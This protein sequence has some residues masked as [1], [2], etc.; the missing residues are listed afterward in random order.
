MKEK[1][2]KLKNVNNIEYIL[3]F[4]YN[5]YKNINLDMRI[6]RLGEPADVAGLAAYLASE[7]ADY[8]NGISFLKIFLNILI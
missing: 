3:I 5:F 1:K 6:N 4:Y 2:N 8:V 7:D